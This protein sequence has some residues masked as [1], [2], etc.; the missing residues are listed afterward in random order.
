MEP[1]EAIPDPHDVELSEPFGAMPI[2]VSSL[3][4]A[5]TELDPEKLLH[6]LVEHEVEFCVIGAVACHRDRRV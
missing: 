5:V 2:Y 3:G 6:V 1:A 4:H